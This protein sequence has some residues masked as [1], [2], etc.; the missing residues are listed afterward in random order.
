MAGE[1]DEVKALL[2]GLAETLAE[3]NNR[4]TYIEG[5]LSIAPPHPQPC[6]HSHKET[7][8]AIT[9]VKGQVAAWSI[10][11]SLAA[12]AALILALFFK[13]P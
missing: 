5:K 4:L 12:L 6:D 11:N 13:Q 1:L 9:T 8:E 2:R 10:L 3:V 7:A